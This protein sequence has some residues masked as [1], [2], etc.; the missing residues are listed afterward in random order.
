MLL[1]GVDIQNHFTKIHFRFGV[2]SLGLNTNLKRIIT[3]QMT[4]VD[5]DFYDHVTKRSV[6]EMITCEKQDKYRI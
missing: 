2:G 5:S 3:V 4:G 1:S 6:P